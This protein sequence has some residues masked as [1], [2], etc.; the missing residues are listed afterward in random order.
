MI[1][2]GECHEV[3]VLSKVLLVIRIQEIYEMID[4]RKQALEIEP[5]L[6]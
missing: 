6:K 3:E 2:Q 1:T 5:L 4:L